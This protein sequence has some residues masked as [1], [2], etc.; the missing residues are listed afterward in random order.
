MGES[1]GCRDLP[2][3]LRKEEKERGACGGVDW[4]PLSTNLHKRE[5]G[6]GRIPGAE[7]AKLLN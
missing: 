6:G 2:V 7:E 4:K 1:P 3:H 5:G